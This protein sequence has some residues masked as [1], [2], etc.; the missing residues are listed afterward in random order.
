MAY[1]KTRLNYQSK[2]GTPFKIG[3]G[4][5]TFLSPFDINKS[6]SSYSRNT[7][8]GQYPALSVKQGRQDAFEAITTPNALGQ[9]N[10]QYP[11]VQDGTVWKRWD[12]AAW[13]N[14]QTGLTSATGKFIEFNTEAKRYT[15]LFN[16]TEK[17]A[18]D[19]SSVTNLTQ[20]PA[21][22]LITVDDYRIY[23]LAGTTL[24]CSAESSITDWTI[25]LNADSIPI[26]SA[27]GIGT[28]LTNFNDVVIAWTEQSMHVLYGNDPY[29]FDWAIPL[30]DGCISNR[31]VITHKK[32]LYF[33]DFGEYKVYTGGKPEVMSHKVQKYLKGINTSY[34]SLCVAGSSGKYIYLSIPYGTATTNNL[35]LEYDTDFDKWYVHNVG[36][37]DFTNIGETL[38]GIDSSGNLYSIN[39]GTDHSGSAISWSH[40]TGV[41]NSGTV[42]Q[43]KVI[44][45]LWLVLDLP[46]TS[47]LTVSYS[48][49]VD[50]DDFTLLYTFTGN[51][52]EQMTRVQIPTTALQ[53][54]DW[55]R[56]KFAGTGP[57]TIHYLQEDLR[58]KAR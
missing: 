47:T 57:C 32:Q 33:L 37:V 56:L 22:N 34:K 44:S 46:T 19:G 13:Q 5:N 3:D 28:A 6:E 45:D 25:L 52:D 23:A 42:S 31:S 15:V 21:T 48:T 8:S 51:A 2:P 26:T 29:D 24:K 35:T 40:I 27:K 4:E 50:N 58:V 20:A 30:S 38:Y 53:N 14:I 10:N 49:T 36:Y 16:G 55:Y 11:H 12:G 54:I 43:K 41:W 17:Y 9:R 18:W 39:D 1:F 7:S